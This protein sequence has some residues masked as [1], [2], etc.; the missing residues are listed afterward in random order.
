MVGVHVITTGGTI[1]MKDDEAA[2]G[3]IPAVSGRDLI[4]LLPEGVGAVEVEEYCNLPSAH[5]TLDTVWGIRAR[6]AELAADDAVQGIVVTHGTDAM[7]ETAYLLDLT[8][9]TDKPIALTGAMRTASEVGYDG[10]VN[11]LAAIRVAASDVCGSLGALVVMNQEI[12]AARH[13][14]KTDTQSTDTFKSLAYG[15]L[16]RVDG[17]E[18]VV[19]QRVVRQYIPC[20][21]LNSDV[22]LIKLAVG[23]D[24]GFL[25]QLMERTAAGVVIAALGG[26][27]VP[28]WWMPTI[29]EA[30]DGGMAVVIASR[31]PTGRVYDGYGYQGA[32]RDLVE[33]GAIFAEGLSG[34]K[35]RIKL[36]VALGEQRDRRSIQELFRPGT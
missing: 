9:D 14:T 35:A 33:A 3:A 4:A 5:F 2:G 30:I 26:G 6:V 16:G 28:P 20:S 15:P 32:Y 34:Q 17:D 27:R 21:T 25:R 29:R 13:V 31:C 19:A 22:H 10:A 7:E 8:V 36:M 1:A 11:L 12:H 18:V 23:M 24:D